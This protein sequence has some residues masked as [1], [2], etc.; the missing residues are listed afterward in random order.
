MFAE[1]QNVEM[2]MVFEEAKNLW[3]TVLLGLFMCHQT[4]VQLTIILEGYLFKSLLH[5]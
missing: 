4:D 5:L 3:L 1:I 2:I